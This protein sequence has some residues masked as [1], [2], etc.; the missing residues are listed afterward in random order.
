MDNGYFAAREGK[1]TA[2]ALLSRAESW[3]DT[4]R[5]SGYLEKLKSMWRAYYGAYFDDVSDGHQITFGGE[6]GEL[7]Q[8]PVNHLRNLAS[9]IITMTTSNRPSME[10]R[11]VNTD[12]KSISQTKLA[13][14]ILDYYMREKRL[15]T[16]LKSAVESAVV[17]A[18]GY[19]KMEWNATT[20]EVYDYFEDERT[21][22]PDPNRPIYEGDIEFSNLS[23]FDVCFDTS[24]ENQK[25][26]WY[27]VRTFKNK[28]DLAAKYPEQAEK[29]K[30]LQTKS[31]IERFRLN[32]ANSLDQTDDIPVYEFYHNRT[33]ALPNGRYML[34]LTD[35]IVLQD[36]GLPYRIIP[37]FRISAG[38]IMG[39]PYGY[40]PMFDIL[41]LQEAINSLY[42]TILTNQN[43]TGVQNFWSKPGAQLNVTELAGGLNL[44][45]SMEKPEVLDLCKTPKEVFEFLGMLERVAET[46]T[47]V[48]SVARGNPEASLKTGAA[49][50]LVQS[51][52]L[53]FMSGLQQSYISLVEDVGGAIIKILQDYAKAP[54][55]IAIVGKTNRTELQEF[56]GDDISKITRVYVDVGN[57]L[58][59]T[60]AGRMELA[61]QMM[62]YQVITNPK[63][64]IEVLNT[65][66]LDVLTE[67]VQDE[68]DL[69]RRENE[70]I[71]EGEIPVVTAIDA[72]NQHILEHR[73]VIQDPDLRKDPALVKRALDHIQMH[74]DAL[75]TTDPAL[76]GLIQQQPLPP[77]AP[78]MN[79]NQGPMAPPQE[80]QTGPQQPM[81][82]PAGNMQLQGAG[83]P[84]GQNLPK[85][86]SVDP[87]MLLNPALQEQTLGNVN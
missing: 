72:H 84:M 16:Y 2:S 47:G 45:E 82:D 78:P 87:T 30:T 8:L 6:Q 15:E 53:Q 42:S 3:S 23:P 57:P 80:G 77:A 69:I 12:Y 33:D 19:I 61:T 48:N 83:I 28:Y 29:I 62:Q 32:I 58:A 51:M 43:A 20:G 37:I 68:L 1:E 65:G 63:Q 59:R 70:V 22:E 67:D 56:V 18:G 40:T 25:Q 60:I 44:I 5:G 79:M 46:L 31:D 81:Q 21:G 52:A 39:T 50:A 11:A 55:M 64:L 4:L 9:H 24:K 76:L 74:I 17:L 73:K 86:A 13:N 66:K 71:T 38:D 14:G 54:R 75:R 34:F 10:A 35:E 36:I 26:D 49:L 27:L 41:P 85:P 7:V